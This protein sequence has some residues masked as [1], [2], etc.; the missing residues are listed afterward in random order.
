M[1]NLLEI[2]NLRKPFCKFV[3]KIPKKKVDTFFKI[4]IRGKKNIPAESP[5]TLIV[6]NHCSYLDIPVVARAFYN[7]LINQ[8]GKNNGQYL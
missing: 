2:I 4:I 5:A 6:A 7:N 3:Y 1:P 8:T